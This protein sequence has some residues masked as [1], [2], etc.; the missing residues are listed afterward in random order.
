MSRAARQRAQSVRKAHAMGLTLQGYGQYKSGQPLA[1]AERSQRGIRRTAAKLTEEAYAPGMKM[2]DQQEARVKDLQHKRDQDN[3]AFADWVSS[4]SNALQAEQIGQQ[5]ATRSALAQGQQEFGTQLQNIRD[6]GVARLQAQGVQSQAGGSLGTLAEQNASGAA[7]NTQSRTNAA[8]AAAGARGDATTATI[9]NNAAYVAAQRAKDYAAS[10]EDLKGVADSRQKLLFQ[11]GQDQ[12]R[13]VQSLL[14]QEITK[15]QAVIAGQQFSTK[16]ENDNANKAA[17]RATT[18]HGQ[19][20]TR[21]NAKDRLAAT[22][23]ADNKYGYSNEQWQRFSN[24]H[25]QRVIKEFND[26]GGGK[27]NGDYTPAQRR[28]AHERATKGRAVAR[29]SLDN[30]KQL[31]SGRTKT[32][33]GETAPKDANVEQLKSWLIQNGVPAD[34][35]TVAAFTTKYPGA[36]IRKHP[37]VWKA[38]N[39]L[40]TRSTGSR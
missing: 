3:A 17:T 20:V 27:K 36:P 22:Q 30:T 28:A 5:V 31:A 2:L 6:A 23:K 32:K 14:G 9:A 15:A 38:W 11:R 37:K 35:A 40:V 33:A 25:R 39:Q 7:A 18:R 24:E 10:L 4:R 21:Q 26:T 8:Q 34:L 13:T 1:L 12:A 16:L 19:N 29:T